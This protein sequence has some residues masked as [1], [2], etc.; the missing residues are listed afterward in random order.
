VTVSPEGGRG[1]W[2][3]PPARRA[4]RTKIRRTAARCGNKASRTLQPPVRGA[5]G[6][7]LT[8]RPWHDRVISRQLQNFIPAPLTFGSL[9]RGWDTAASRPHPR[10]EISRSN[11]DPLLA[12]RYRRWGNEPS[13]CIPT[14]VDRVSRLLRRPL[15]PA[16]SALRVDP[17]VAYG[18]EQSASNR[19]VPNLARPV[20]PG[21]VPIKAGISCMRGLLCF[22]PL[23]VPALVVVIF[24]SLATSSS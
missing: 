18:P 22:M 20:V 9:L 17:Q 4:M 5:A 13:E 11:V 10:H 24:N 23:S 3:G 15:R 19:P 16:T 7:Q 1:K 8:I 2:L 12:I 6:I 21:T 14:P